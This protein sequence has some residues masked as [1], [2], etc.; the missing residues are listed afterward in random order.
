M[1]ATGLGAKR[2]KFVRLAM[3]GCRLTP[4]AVSL[5]E[6]AKR[7]GLSLKALRRLLR[8][9]RVLVHVRGGQVRVPVS[10]LARLR[11]PAPALPEPLPRRRR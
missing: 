9:R 7:I 5:L 11:R 6:A 3:R 4:T 2:E 1:S 8:V 10:E